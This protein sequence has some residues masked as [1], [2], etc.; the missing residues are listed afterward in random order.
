MRINA[1][2]L[3]LITQGYST[4]YLQVPSDIQFMY[5]QDGS[6]VFVPI[7]EVRRQTMDTENKA[8]YYCVRV[9]FSDV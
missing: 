6:A 3:E 9:A 2:N 5:S 1:S 7:D 4:S 8:E